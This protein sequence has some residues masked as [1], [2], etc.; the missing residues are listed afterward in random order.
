MTLAIRHALLCAHTADLSPEIQAVCP[1]CRT[2]Q[3]W[4]GFQSVVGYWPEELVCESCADEWAAE[5][6]ADRAYDAHPG[7]DF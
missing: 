1:K 2:W 5:A 4:V 3:P 6:D 7:G